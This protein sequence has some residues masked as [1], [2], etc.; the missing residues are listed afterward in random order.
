MGLSR[1]QFIKTSTVAAA[2][3]YIPTGAVASVD[4]KWPDDLVGK[5]FTKKTS[6]SICRFFNINYRSLKF[7]VRPATIFHN[8]SE[9]Q[10]YGTY[11]V[12]GKVVDVYDE[13]KEEYVTLSILREVSK[14]HQC[15]LNPHSKKLI[16]GN[17]SHAPF[18]ESEKL[19][20][21]KQLQK[22]G[23]LYI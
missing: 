17:Y 12:S 23:R 15:N 6:E 10:G 5:S 22:E 7:E 16:F 11:I 18:S 13:S 19:R 21:M 14:A 4:T 20:R 8:G 1:R 9:I 2:S 3:L